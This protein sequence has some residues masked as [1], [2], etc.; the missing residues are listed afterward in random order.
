MI[1]MASLNAGS[2]DSLKRQANSIRGKLNVLSQC[3]QKPI[4]VCIALTHMDQIEGF[5]AFQAFLRGNGIPLN[6][7]FF[8]SAEIGDKKEV[9][10]TVSLSPEVGVRTCLESLE[11]CLEPYETLLSRALTI[12]PAEDFLQIIAFMRRAPKL[13]SRL[14]SFVDILENPDALSASPEIVQL[15]PAGKAE[16]KGHGTRPLPLP[17][18]EREDPQT[19]PDTQA[20]DCSRRHSVSGSFL[21]DFRVCL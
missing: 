13:L 5:S 1:D 18:H 21:P 8:P 20:P 11:T 10:E 19:E 9:K 17:L 2:S 4:E 3:S 16:G 12:Q 15:F 14:S 6:I 7:H